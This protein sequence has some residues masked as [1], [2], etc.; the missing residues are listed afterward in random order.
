MEGKKGQTT[1]SGRHRRDC[2]SRT[3]EYHFQHVRLNSLIRGTSSSWWPSITEKLA[4]GSVKGL[5]KGALESDKTKTAAWIGVSLLATA[6]LAS[7]ASRSRMEGDFSLDDSVPEASDFSRSDD[8]AHPAPSF[9]SRMLGTAKASI[10]RDTKPEPATLE[11][12]SSSRGWL[13]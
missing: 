7:F 3:G 5:I 10:D 11:L 12:T 4:S 2:P 13:W 6:A 8:A 1:G 9:I